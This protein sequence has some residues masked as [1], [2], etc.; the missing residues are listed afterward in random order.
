MKKGDKSDTNSYRPVSILP[1]ASKILECL[2]FKNVFYYFLNNTL[3]TP[4]QSGFASGDGTIN[5]LTY[6]YYVFAEALDQR[7]NVQ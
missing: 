4:H 5:Q 3:K 2:V 1:C 7:K 6:L